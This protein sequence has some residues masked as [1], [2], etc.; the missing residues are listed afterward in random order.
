MSGGYG[1]GL[2]EDA[3]TTLLTAAALAPSV[4]NTQP[5]RFEVGSR[6]V[7]V[8]RDLDRWLQAGDPRMS[9]LYMSLGAAVLN[10]RVAAAELG[11]LPHVAMLPDPNVPDL[12]ARLELAT[13][14]G[15][16]AELATLF[17]YLARR[18]T[19]RMPFTDRWIPDSVVRELEYAARCAGALLRIERDPGRVRRLLGLAAE[20]STDEL[21]DLDVLVER[22]HWVGGD[23]T[24]DG[25]PAY[26][27]GPV[28]VDH[29]AVVR[30]LA[31]RQV[32]RERAS[33]RFERRPVLAVLSVSRD[34]EVGWLNA[35]QALERVLL[36]AARSGLSASLLSQ[37]LNS[38][39]HRWLVHEPSDGDMYP[40][41]LL[42]LGYARLPE[43]TPRRP[44]EDLE[45]GACSST[46]GSRR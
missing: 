33:A 30:E 31:V 24:H 18:R 44:L 13:G 14:L 39:Q 6:I 26:A 11:R 16:D 27:L 1:A 34:D 29:P 45:P 19:S 9:G 2:G 12:V 10:L 23:R 35:G 25:V 15:A 17:P 40:Q 42:R 41:M 20:A 21:F 22:A 28:P 38:R 7:R 4:H 46:E 43:P 32:D 3:R 8:Y 37:A 36:T 5:W